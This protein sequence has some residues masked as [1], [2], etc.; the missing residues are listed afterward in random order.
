M[1]SPGRDEECEDRMLQIIYGH[2]NPGEE[3]AGE[4]DGVIGDDYSSQF[5]NDSGEGV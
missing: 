1:D 3:D 5:L 4:E 2:A